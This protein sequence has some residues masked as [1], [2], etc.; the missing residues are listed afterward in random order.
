[1]DQVFYSPR[2]NWICHLV[3]ETKKFF[4]ATEVNNHVSPN[5]SQTNVE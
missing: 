1:M 4:E 5:S 3:N 2:L